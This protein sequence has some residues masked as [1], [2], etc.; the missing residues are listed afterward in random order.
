LCPISPDA[1]NGQRVAAAGVE[2]TPAPAYLCA[3]FE[4]RIRRA[5]AVAMIFAAL[6]LPIQADAA[7]PTK[8]PA[9]PA[10][11]EPP[12]GTEAAKP[13]GSAD[14]WTAYE[15]RDST[16]RVCYVYGEP[17]KSEPAGAKRKQPMIMVTHRPEE[18]IANVVSVMEG[19][20]LK[21]GSDVVLD[22]G[23]NK[24]QLFTKEDSAWARTSELDRTIV[25]A[26]SKAPQVVVKGDPQ[27]G[28]ATTDV[29]PLAGFAK[30]MG[31]IDKACGIA[32]A[33]TS[34]PAPA[35]HRA[36]HPAKHEAKREAKHQ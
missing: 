23:K 20:P 32:T 26:M 1:Q 12:A 17:K 11:H 36:K 9:K 2:F 34:A 22:L 8:K 5:G 10:H 4:T 24:F 27:K 19:Y 13:L 3:M 21:D 33:A 28:P 15:A 25:T 31:L 18:K 6:A 16:G 29:Y 14:S 35:A 7:Q 30:A